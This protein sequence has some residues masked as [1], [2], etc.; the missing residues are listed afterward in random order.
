ME[1]E[2]THRLNL[3]TQIDELQMHTRKLNQQISD[4]TTKD[5]AHEKVIEDQKMQILQLE[6]VRYPVC[7]NSTMLASLIPCY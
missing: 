5:K 6:R 1:M 4:L 7:H 2:Q 3:E